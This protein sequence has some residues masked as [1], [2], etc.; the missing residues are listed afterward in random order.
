ML[1]VLLIVILSGCNKFGPTDK[2]KGELITPSQAELHKGTE[3]LSMEFVKGQPPSG[4]WEGESFPITVKIQNNGAYNIQNG[5]MKMTGNL[6]F[7]PEF[8]SDISSSFDLEGKSQFNPEG[9]FSFEKYQATAGTVD[10]DKT[11]SFFIVA[12]YPYKTIASASICIN[13]RV[14]SAEDSAAPSGEC[15][16][17]SISLSGGQGAPVAVTSIDEELT[18]LGENEIRLILKIHISNLGKG[19]V[20]KNDAYSNDCEGVALLPDDAGVIN[21]RSVS[22]SSYR[23]DSNEYSVKCQN[24]KSDN[25]FAL[26]P[27]G[28]FTLE[29]YADLDLGFIGATAFTTPLNVELD[30]GYSQLSESKS[31]IIKNSDIIK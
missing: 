12:C 7:V 16:S 25:T 30:Y 28:K 4:V 17:G 6:Y 24:L 31:I 23:L 3:G 13:P 29:C 8:E 14:I 1:L 18:P 15:K 20:V 9:E 5:R 22:F 26:D 21:V 19:K 10:E 2:T 27:S 11:D